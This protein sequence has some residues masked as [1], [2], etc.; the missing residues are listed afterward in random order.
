MKLALSLMWVISL[1]L[2]IP[3]FSYIS[4]YSYS[5]NSCATPNFNMCGNSLSLLF[6][7]PLFLMLYRFTQDEAKKK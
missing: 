2:S 7:T 3:G 5:V 6:F 4:C 1:L